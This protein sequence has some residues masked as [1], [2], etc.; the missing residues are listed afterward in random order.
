MIRIFNNYPPNNSGKPK[1]GRKREYGGYNGEER[2]KRKY[3]NLPF[4]NSKTKNIVP[5]PFIDYN[6]RCPKKVNQT[7]FK[8]KKD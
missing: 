4:V 2:K 6:C 8:I 7:Y 5:L 3:R 1:K